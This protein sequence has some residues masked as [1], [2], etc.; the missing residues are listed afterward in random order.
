MPLTS[1][2]RF[3]IIDREKDYTQL[4]S[5]SYPDWAQSGIIYEVYLRAFSKDGNIKS[6]T[7]KVADLKELG[8]NIIWLMPIHLIGHIKRKGPLGSPYSIRDYYRIN[9]EYGNKDDFKELIK[10]CHKHDIKVLL[11]FVANHAANDHVELKKHPEWFKKDENGKFSRRI[12]GWSDVIDFDYTNNELREYMKDVAGYWIKE[13]DIDGYRCDV[14]GMVPEDF[15]LE[16]RKELKNIKKD[17]LFVAEW[18]DPEMHLKTFDV[19]YDWILYYKLDELQNGSVNAQE[20]VDLILKR[21][22]QFP[23]KALRLRFLENHD[24]ARA[25]YKF[26]A[27]SYRTYA[28]FIYT[29]DGIPLIYNGQEVGDPKHLTLFDKNA[30]NWKVRG[31]NEYK[32]LYKTLISL[33]LNN[34]VFTQGSLFRIENSNPQ[35]IASY[36]RKLGDVTAIIILNFGDHESIVNLKSDIEINNWKLINLSELDTLDFSTDQLKFSLKAHDGYILLSHI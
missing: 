9:S 19:T 27:S 12:P 20:I 26:G 36:G 4:K 14:A 11:D 28:A 1:I 35:Y 34:K 25:T 21:I 3:G 5:M 17:L 6:L 18:E 30:I 7:K 24:Q 2:D 15:W 16:L 22:D 10:E 31:A 33:R 23:N 32:K 13:F 29:I 8:I